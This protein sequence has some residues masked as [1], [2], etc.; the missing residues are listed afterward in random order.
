MGDDKYRTGKGG[1]LQIELANVSR[2]YNQLKEK[3]TFQ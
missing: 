2:E 3:R 1:R